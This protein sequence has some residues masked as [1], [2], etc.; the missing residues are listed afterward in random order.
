MRQHLIDRGIIEAQRVEVGDL[1]TFESFKLINAM[2][3]F[4]FPER[5]IS[6]VIE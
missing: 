1:S 4:D 6:A 5:P 2:L 3:R